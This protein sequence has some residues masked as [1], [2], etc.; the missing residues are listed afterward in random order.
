MDLNEFPKVLQDVDFLNW[1]W[2][3]STGLPK[4]ARQRGSKKGMGWNGGVHM[5]KNVKVVGGLGSLA[6]PW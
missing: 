3:K 1:I 2:K 6:M 5:E 4:R